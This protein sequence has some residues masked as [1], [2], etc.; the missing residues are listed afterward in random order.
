MSKVKILHSFSEFN[1]AINQ[2]SPEQLVVIAFS[3]TWCGPCKVMKPVF[4]SFSI[5]YP[6]VSFAKVDV[7]E[8]QQAAQAAGVTSM[9]TYQ[10]YKGGRKIDEM[11]GANGPQLEALLKQHSGSAVAEGSNYGITGYSDLTQYV[12]LNQLDCLNQQQDHSVRNIFVRGPNYLESDVDEQ[13]IVVVPFNQAV[14]LHSI[15]FVGSG[16]QAPKT[17][18]LYVNRY[19]LGFDEAE[20][21]EPTQ[22]LEL[23]ERDFQEDEVTPLRF[24]KFQN[25]NS[26]VLFIEDNQ[27]D[28]ETTKLEQLVFIGTPAEKVDIGNLKKLDEQDG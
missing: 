8:V 28:E 4:D 1:D 9:P 18:K 3:A 5:K 6:S 11:K 17:V 2:A 16:P 27:G 12:T 20:S 21:V 13:L 23:T 19:T 26:I 14:R 24:V 25:V 7:D 22:V 15:K 10:F